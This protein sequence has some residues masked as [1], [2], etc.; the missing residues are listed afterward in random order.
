[1]TMTK[2]I[3]KAISLMILA[4]IIIF[5]L[6]EVNFVLDFGGPGIDEIPDPQV[7]SDYERCYQQEDAEIHATAFGTIDNPDVQKEFISANRA[8]AAAKCR[9]LHPAIMIP[10]AGSPG[11]N[12]VDL[13]P[14]FW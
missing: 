9:D 3:S 8:R 4:G 5:V 10:V 13:Q 1:M 2:A 14:R 12:L 6:F 11:F 7:E